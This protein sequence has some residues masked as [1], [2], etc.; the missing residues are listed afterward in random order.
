MPKADVTI[1]EAAG[2]AAAGGEQNLGRKI[3]M[4]ME[5]AVAECFANGITDDNAIRDAKL[6]ARQQAK[7]GAA[8]AQ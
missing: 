7:A 8:A 5:A 6:A 4:A 1:V 2:T 3:Q